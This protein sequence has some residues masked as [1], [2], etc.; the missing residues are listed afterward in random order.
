VLANPVS[1]AVRE[2]QKGTADVDIL[3]TGDKD[4]MDV[5]TEKPELLTPAQFLQKY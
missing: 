1:L 4:F 2:V 3:I 5:V